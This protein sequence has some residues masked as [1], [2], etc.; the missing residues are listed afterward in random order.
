MTIAE[1]VVLLLLA[2]PFSTLLAVGAYWVL[3]LANPYRIGAALLVF[4]VCEFVLHHLCAKIRS[5]VGPDALPG[6][7]AEVMTEFR[8]HENGFHSG[9]VRLDG[10]RWSARIVL[11]D[12]SPPVP[13]ARVQVVRVEGLTLWVATAGGQAREHKR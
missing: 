12:G 2:L 1:R 9:H 11:I 4:V 5:P 8:P 3:N 13:G 7:E 10:V 6:R